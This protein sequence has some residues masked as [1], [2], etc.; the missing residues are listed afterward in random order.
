[1]LQESIEKQERRLHRLKHST[2]ERIEAETGE[3]RV[4][5]LEVLKRNKA[6]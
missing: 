4:N 2:K 5:R 6:T 1:M 3:E